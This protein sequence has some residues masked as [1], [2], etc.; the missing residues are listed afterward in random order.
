MLSS[1]DLSTD[2]RSILDLHLKFQWVFIVKEAGCGD[3]EGVRLGWN[4]SSGWQWQTLLSGSSELSQLM[5]EDSTCM[6]DCL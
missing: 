1:E 5:G 4:T 2:Y 6:L 3:V